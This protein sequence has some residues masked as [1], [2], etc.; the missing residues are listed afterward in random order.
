MYYYSSS[1]EGDLQFATADALIIFPYCIDA[2]FNYTVV[3]SG[4]CGFPPM[5]MCVSERLWREDWRLS[6]LI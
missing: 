4:G 5:L 2:F 3:V 6:F 1:S